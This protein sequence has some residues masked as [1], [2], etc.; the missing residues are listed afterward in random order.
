MREEHHGKSDETKGERDTRVCVCVQH[1]V[2]CRRIGERRAE[3]SACVCICAY[4]FKESQKRGA[5]ARERRRERAGRG[6]RVRK[7]QGG[8]AIYR[9]CEDAMQV[10][11][12][13]RISVRAGG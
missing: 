12:R 6:G 3:A 9:W 8:S 13:I 10:S 7:G 2:E 11:S 1:D 4:M 5:T